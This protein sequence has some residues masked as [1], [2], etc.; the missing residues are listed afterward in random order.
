MTEY[1]YLMK[2]RMLAIEKVLLNIEEVIGS[3][4]VTDDTNY[5]NDKVQHVV[6]LAFERIA[7]EY[8]FVIP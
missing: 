1:E 5:D 7:N 8:E 2:A 6:E 4:D 3:F